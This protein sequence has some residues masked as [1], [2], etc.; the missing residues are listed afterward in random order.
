MPAIEILGTLYNTAPESPPVP[1]PGWHV[2]STGEIPA[3]AAY[4]VTPATPRSAFL[5]VPTWHYTFASREEWEQL[6]AGLDLSD[7]PPPKVRKV[8][9]RQAWIWLRRAGLLAAVEAAVAAS[10]DPEL[11]DWWL[12]STEVHIDAPPLAVLLPQIGL[13]PQEL[14]AIFEAASML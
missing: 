8:M 11:S 1:L 12:K 9:M 10:P 6:R 5:G 2:N 4:R 7:P 13:T 3:L 14:P